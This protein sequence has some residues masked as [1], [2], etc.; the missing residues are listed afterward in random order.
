MTQREANKRRRAAVKTAQEWMVKHWIERLAIQDLLREQ[1][2][3]RRATRVK[4][5]AQRPI[6]VRYN[7]QTKETEVLSEYRREQMVPRSKYQPGC[8]AR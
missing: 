5:L 7:P 8:G 3:E 1:A 4:V 2:G 6:A